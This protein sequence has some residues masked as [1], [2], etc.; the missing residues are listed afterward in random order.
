MDFITNHSTEILGVI[1]ALYGLVRAI[2]ILTPTKNDDEWLNQNISP[3]IKKLA[4]LFGLDLKQGRKI[5]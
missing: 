1:I 2:I 4:A 5:K 3:I